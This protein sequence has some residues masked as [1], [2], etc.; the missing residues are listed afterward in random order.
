[1]SAEMGNS[2][3][4]TGEFPDRARTMRRKV[5]PADFADRRSDGSKPAD[6]WAIVSGGAITSELLARAGLV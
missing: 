3:A 1:M 4:R 5:Q 6:I 2:A